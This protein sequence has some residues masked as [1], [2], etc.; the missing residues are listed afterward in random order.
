MSLCTCSCDLSFDLDNHY[1][2]LLSSLFGR[3]SR[4]EVSV[5]KW[6]W[7]SGCT[8]DIYVASKG[9][10]V[11]S[12][13]VC[14][15]LL[16]PRDRAPFLVIQVSFSTELPGAAS[17]CSQEH[18][19]LVLSIKHGE[20]GLGS[21]VLTPC[22][23]SMF[24]MGLLIFHSHFYPDPRIIETCVVYFPLLVSSSYLLVTDFGCISTLT[25]GHSPYDFYYQKFIESC[26]MSQESVLCCLVTNDPKT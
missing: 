2:H 13:W 24:L 20:L 18:V 8:K 11:G 17:V 19:R 23:A 3:D 25:L 15:A 16:L 1:R 6:Q 10:Q 4:E 21:G 26:I 14:A 7:N 12:G 5:N 22:K 9:G